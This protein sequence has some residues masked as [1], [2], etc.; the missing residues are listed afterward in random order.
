[1]PCSELNDVKVNFRFLPH[2]ERFNF[3]YVLTVTYFQ[4]RTVLVENLPLGFSVESIQEK[5]GTVGKYVIWTRIVVYACIA[6]DI[7]C[8]DILK[9]VNNRC[10]I[11]LKLTFSFHIPEL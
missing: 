3:I 11:T 4:K 5:F 10:Y 7:L 2:S 1:M 9:A 8:C 6:P